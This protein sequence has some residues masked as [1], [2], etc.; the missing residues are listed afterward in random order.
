[1]Q[2]GGP[3]KRSSRDPFD[4]RG[5]PNR[6]VRSAGQRAPPPERAAPALLVA[7]QLW[8]ELAEDNGT[9][10]PGSRPAESPSGAS[11]GPPRHV[12]ILTRG[13]TVIDRPR[14]MLLNRYLEQGKPIARRASG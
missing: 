10:R 2:G 14:G 6:C 1:M 9:Q 7:D 3:V 13:G 12:R 11:V 4:R 5:Y 8:A